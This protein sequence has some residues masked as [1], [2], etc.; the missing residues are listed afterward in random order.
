MDKKYDLEERT[1][2]FAVRAL[3]LIIAKR[4][5]LKVEKISNIK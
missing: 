5:M 1:A 4:M 2:K 3:E